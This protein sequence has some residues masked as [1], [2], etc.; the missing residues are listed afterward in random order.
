MQEYL[1]RQSKVT[2][3]VLWKHVLS[4]LLGRYYIID[5]HGS[6]HNSRDNFHLEFLL[7]TKVL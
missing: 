5:H 6:I 3:T 4:L 2:L 7:W 1:Q